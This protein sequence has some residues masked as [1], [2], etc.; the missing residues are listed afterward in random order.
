MERR[1]FQNLSVVVRDCDFKRDR[2]QSVRNS[3]PLID[4][5]KICIALMSDTDEKDFSVLLIQSAE[6]TTD[7]CRRSRVFLA[8]NVLRGIL[9]EYG[10]RMRRVQRTNSVLPESCNLS[11]RSDVGNS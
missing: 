10:N 8:L 9:T 7:R 5:M 6:T 3:E 1:R 4:R 11:K 2:I